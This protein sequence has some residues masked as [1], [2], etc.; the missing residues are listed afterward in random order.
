MKNLLK[1][2]GLLKKYIKKYSC[3][4][5]SLIITD[6]VY[7]E[8]KFKRIFG[9][10]LDLN[11]PQT[12][13]E[14]MQWMKLYRHVTDYNSFADKLLVR[15]YVENVIGKD[16]LIPVFATYKSEKELSIDKLP[17]EPF[18]IKT[19]HDSSGGIIVRDKTK[20]N[21]DDAKSFCRFNLK[22]NH[23][24]ISRERHY[25]KLERRII[26]EKLLLTKSGKIPNDYKINC[27]NGKAEFI[28]C[29]I[30]REGLNYRKIYDRNWSEMGFK[31]GNKQDF[32]SK[33][34]GP[35]I[36]RPKKLDK[37]IEYAEAL[38]KGFPYLRI[39]LYDVDGDIFLGEITIY[40]GGGFDVIEPKEFDLY[41]GNKM[42][43]DI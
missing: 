34:N 40:H 16:V 33:F 9:Y 8:R 12:M 38:S 22:N 20:L 21:I 36:D 17:D 5:C 24:Y 10:K 31:W 6:R 11:N 30:D 13:N 29:A 18:I 35:N 39:D 19:N 28:Y 1:R 3:F 2:Y 14:K 42:R 7:I 27:I 43:L 26:I 15:D 41:F 4:L 37:M 23:Y 25:K 32:K